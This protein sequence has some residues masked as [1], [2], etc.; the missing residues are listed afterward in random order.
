MFMDCVCVIGLGHANV[1]GAA[2]WP[3]DVYLQWSILHSE[4][5]SRFIRRKIT[6]RANDLLRLNFSLLNDSDFGS[7]PV[8][9]CLGSQADD[10]TRS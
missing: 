10:D 3:S 2:A 8:M 5:S 1:L 4:H 6:T 7:N 9:D